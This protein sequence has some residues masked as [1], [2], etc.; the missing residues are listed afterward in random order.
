[1]KAV[2]AAAGY[3]TRL[4]PLTDDFAKPLLPVGGRP[5]LDWLLDKVREVE[6][7]D[8][9]HVVTNSRYAEAFSEWAAARDVVVHDDGTHSN[10][11]R[12]G[13]IGDL[14]LV[15]ER[16]HLQGDDLLVLAGDNLFDFSL[17][18]YVSWWRGKGV[19]SA[20]AVH[21]CGDLELATHY[22]IVD[23]TLD[24]RVFFFVEKPADPPSTLAA[25]ACYLLHRDHVPLVDAYLDA[26]HAPD[27]MG[28]LIGW[29]YRRERL[30]GY[31][32]DGVWLDIGNH[33]Q[34]LEADNLMRRRQGLPEVE[35]YE[36]D[37]DRDLTQS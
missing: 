24:D 3:A 28:N 16:A 22:G 32:F 11:D 15:I 25:T 9:I 7:I 17:V 23:L 20:L 37:P 27:P 8:G 35:R 29:L 4:R 5:M 31:R 26:G 21:D 1:M 33:A 12:L 34:L 14:R 10:E 30:Y 36:L 2:I 18:D 6:E 13:G 19:A